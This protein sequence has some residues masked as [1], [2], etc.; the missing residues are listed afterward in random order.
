[1]KV[2]IV[3]I[4]LAAAVSALSMGVV[5]ATNDNST[6]VR[7]AAKRLES[8]RIEFA[9][10]QRE[11]DGSWGDRILPTRRFFPASGR[12]GRWL[13][14]S[15]FAVTVPTPTPG[16]MLSVA[17]YAEWCAAG[18]T[19]DELAEDATWGDYS[20]MLDSAINE[21]LSITPPTAL[22]HFHD[23]R[24]GGLILLR[25]AA[26]ESRQD[27][28]V[29]LADLFG[30]GLLYAW[31]VTRAQDELPDDV[32]GALEKTGC[33]DA[34]DEP[35]E[36]FGAAAVPTPDSTTDAVPTPVPTASL[37]EIV[38]AGRVDIIVHAIE[39]DA[40]ET[41]EGVSTTRIDIEFINSRGGIEAVS[42]QQVEGID[43]EGLNL[44]PYDY[45]H[46]YDYAT[47][48]YRCPSVLAYEELNPGASVRGYV[49]FVESSFY[50]LEFIQLR[51][52][53]GGYL[54]EVDPKVVIPAP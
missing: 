12:E 5:I 1:M 2:L 7:I 43:T 17:E 32:R 42:D 27:A 53:M 24:I 9:L 13:T 34:D 18:G 48:T 39:R 11:Q 44:D 41:A 19:I 47:Y 23:A 3:V 20:S 29:S 35:D 15:S 14:S 25:L 31:R 45:C 4:A 8:G 30:P 22:H 54:Y 51:K 33:I 52:R 36:F 10:Q 6:E 26:A 46:E 49:Y 40:F 28:E 21:G 37:G 38:E 50:P 16:P